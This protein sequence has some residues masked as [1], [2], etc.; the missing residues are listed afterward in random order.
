MQQIKQVINRIR[1]EIYKIK[2]HPFYFLAFPYRL[3]TAKR[4]ALPDFLIIGTQKGG[5]LSLLNFLSQHP[6]IR[7]AP[8]EVHYFDAESNYKK[9]ELWYRSHFPIRDTI[10]P[11]EFVGEK[12]PEYLF[13]PDAAK[14]IQKD[15]PNVKLI[16]LLRNPTE[17][18]ISHYFMALRKGTKQ[19]PISE[20]M[21]TR[22]ERPRSFKKRGLYLEQIKRYESYLKKKQ[23]LILSSEEFFVNPQKVLKQVFDFLGVD[24]TFKC[25]DLSPR[26][27]ASNKAPVPRE[28]YDYINEYFKPHNQRLY[29]YLNRDFG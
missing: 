4:R 22:E 16:C 25:R 3:A 13:S 10:N 8:Q 28:V 6:Q 1:R 17:R 27:V 24:K 2:R 5:T 21:M 20:A 18:A 26:S 11:G 9:G 14:R 19:H 15:L 7:T 29:N 12:T 23:L